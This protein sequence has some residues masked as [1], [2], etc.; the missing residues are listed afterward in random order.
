VDK[1]QLE[2][3]LSVAGNYTVIVRGQ[4]EG[5]RWVETTYKLAAMTS[6]EDAYEFAR[7]VGWLKEPPEVRA[8]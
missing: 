7:R 1:I 8:L 6:L 4:D 3:L 2:I 5:D